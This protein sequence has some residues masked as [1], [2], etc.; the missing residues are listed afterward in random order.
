VIAMSWVVWRQYRAA[1]A[2]TAALVA[3]FAALIVVTGVQAASQWH[4]ALAACTASRACGNLS[5]SS[6]FLGSHAIGFLVIMT[7]G[8]PAVLGILAG[9]PLLAHEFE[10]GTNQYAWTQSVTRRRWLAVKTG[11][12]LLAAA[13]IA[14]VVS[15][16]V[17]WW[18]GPNNALQANAFDPGRFDIMGIV[19]VGYAVFATALGITAGAL[20]RR[21]LPAIAVT[22]AGFIAVR[23]VIFMVLRRSFMTAVTSY[24]PIGS[25][26]APAGS[27]WQLAAGFVGGDGQPLILP[28]STNGAVIGGVGA[29]V[30]LPVSSLPAQ[31]QAAAGN[32]PLTAAAYH[33]VVSCAQAHGIRGYVTYQPASRYWAFQGIETGIFLLLAAALIAVAFAVVSRR[34]A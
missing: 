29:G 15:A 21:T 19:P 18:S 32:G 27:A 6:L 25:G 11:W 30:G 23:A 34:D 7:L 28:L 4:S 9:A 1:A 22:L 33:A 13:A 12:L 14:G 8:V 20:L 16:L 24:F 3:A 2:I 5:S 31:C 10:T 17:T 26:F